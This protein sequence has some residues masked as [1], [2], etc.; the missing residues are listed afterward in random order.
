MSRTAIVAIAA[1][2]ALLTHDP[3]CPIIA[4]TVAQ[5]GRKI[6]ADHDSSFTRITFGLGA[7]DFG[8]E[9]AV[10]GI[11][12]YD[13]GSGSSLFGMRFM[14]AVKFCIF[15]C[16]EDLSR[17]ELGFLYGGIWRSRFLSASIAGGLGLAAERVS[18]DVT[19]FDPYNYSDPYTTKVV[20]T[21]SIRPTLPLSARIGFTPLPWLGLTA[22]GSM[23]IAMSALVSQI[24]VG[25]QLGD[26]TP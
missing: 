6:V 20:V 2:A 23:S 9:G 11:V 26:L 14:P 18:R 21:T 12:E 15:G 8:G 19:S 25:I 16:S 10:S 4:S 22:G 5:Q 17:V 7:G 13:A 1:L 24:H 3:F